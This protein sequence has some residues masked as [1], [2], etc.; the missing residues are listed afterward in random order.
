MVRSAGA[1]PATIAIVHGD[2]CIGLN[3]SQLDH[4]ASANISHRKASTRDI[5]PVI[6]AK[7]SAGTTVAATSFI[8]S[9]VGI[10]IFATGGV[11]GVHANGQQTLDISADLIQ[12]SRTPIVVVSSGLKSILDVGRSLEFLETHGV[13]V[14]KFTGSLDNHPALPTC[15]ECNCGKNEN[16]EPESDFPNFWTRTSGLKSPSSLSDPCQAAEL[17][18]LHEALKNPSGILIANPIP[19]RCELNRKLVAE[20]L[21][22]LNQSKSLVSPNLPHVSSNIDPSGQNVTPDLL[23]RINDLTEGATLRANTCLIRSNALLAGLIA[24]H[25]EKVCILGR[26]VTLYNIHLATLYAP[27]NVA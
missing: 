9:N 4:L 11:G 17:I 13:T 12:L 18:R 22:Q 1:V 14:T 2:I 27:F 21:V 15:D 3:D 25:Y 20:A 7:E 8:A 5:S 10:K 26:S 19:K 16:S 23:S 24:R 6:L